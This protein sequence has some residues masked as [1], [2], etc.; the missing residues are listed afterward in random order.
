MEG[1]SCPYWPIASMTDDVVGASVRLMNPLERRF[2]KYSCRRCGRWMGTVG[3]P[4]VNGLGTRE[5]TIRKS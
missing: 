3:G 1:V 4:F 5:E 2:S